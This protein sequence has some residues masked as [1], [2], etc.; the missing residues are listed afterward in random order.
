MGTAVGT[1]L[2]VRVVTG[3]SVQE[4]HQS[5]GSWGQDVSLSGNSLVDVS[6]TQGP[7]CLD[8]LPSEV[9]GPAPLGGVSQG[10]HL[11]LTWTELPRS[12]HQGSP[13]S[14]QSSFGLW[15]GGRENEETLPA[16]RPPILTP[17]PPQL[18]SEFGEA[19]RF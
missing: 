4:W 15:R 11:D 13:F 6:L 7:T 16:T 5:D 12:S 3:G 18:D 17:L 2:R 1:E 8:C 14:V 19:S 10:G 9:G